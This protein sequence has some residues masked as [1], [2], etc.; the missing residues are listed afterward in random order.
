MRRRKGTLTKET[1]QRGNSLKRL[2]C[3]CGREVLVDAD[4][5]E[6][7]CCMCIMKQMPAPEVGAKKDEVKH[8]V[9]FPQGWRWKKQFVHA[10]GRVF[11][12]GEE[13]VALKG[14]LPPTVI[15]SKFERRKRRE[16]R[17]LKKQNRL[18]KLHKKKL[19]ESNA[20]RP[21]SPTGD[22]ILAQA[23]AG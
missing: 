6:V 18:A 5:V 11:E 9:G 21:G 15:P 7:K 17:E 1:L 12:K 10:D 8:E 23:F 2:A 13:N 4:C 14:T 20:R 22:G 16:E 19:K 3:N